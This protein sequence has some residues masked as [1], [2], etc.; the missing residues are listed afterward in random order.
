MTLTRVDPWT[1]QQAYGYAQAWRVDSPR[2][3]VVVAGLAVPGMLLEVE[4]LAAV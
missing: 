3:F 2:G 1:W 4:A